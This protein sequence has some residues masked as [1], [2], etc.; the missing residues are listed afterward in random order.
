MEFLRVQPISNGIIGQPIF[1]RFLQWLRHFYKIS[2]AVKM[3]SMDFFR[4]KNERLKKT[5]PQQGMQ[6]PIFEVDLASS[7]NKAENW[8]YFKEILSEKMSCNIMVKLVK[9]MTSLFLSQRQFTLFLF[10]VFLPLQQ[11]QSPA[12]LISESSVN[13]KWSSV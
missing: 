2:F 13:L 1:F 10:P 9:I 8:S 7:Y 4:G 3:F 5:N 11:P 6:Q 12:V